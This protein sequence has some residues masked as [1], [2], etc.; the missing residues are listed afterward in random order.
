MKAGLLDEGRE[1]RPEIEQSMN[2]AVRAPR[3]RL[4]APPDSLVNSRLDHHGELN[5]SRTLLV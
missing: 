1:R 5:K 3:D 2:T 4:A